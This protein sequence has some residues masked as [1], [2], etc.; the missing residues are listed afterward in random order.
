MPR[1]ITA[2][3]ITLNEERN[4]EAAVRS[5]LRVCDEVIVVDSQS[6]DR[7]VEL[8][9]KAGAKVVVQPYLGDGPQKHFGVQF[10]RND[11][12]FSLDADERFDENAVAALEAMDLDNASCARYA[13]RRKT[14]VGDRW[15]KIWYPDW[16][17][18]LYHKA[19]AAYEPSI[20]HA[21]V[22]GGQ[23]G[24]IDADLLHYSYASYADLAGRV[25]KFSARGAKQLLQKGRPVSPFAPA[26]HAAARFFKHYVVK[27]GFLYGVDGL[28]I[29]VT[30]AYVV[31]MKYAIA[32]EEQRKQRGSSGA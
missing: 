26:A 2:T 4:V 29:A 9:Q 10:A 3:I 12:I 21:S 24:R 18:R 6:S 11:W 22:V 7:T 27:R 5:A 31:Y 23:S 32:V 14:Y 16:T 17:T 1:P 15:I 19:R 25:P 13:I 28:N 30:S 20:G 8:A